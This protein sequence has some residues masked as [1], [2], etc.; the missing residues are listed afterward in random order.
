[1][2][3]II[4]RLNVTQEWEKES[5]LFAKHIREDYENLW[6]TYSF[7]KKFMYLRELERNS[8]VRKSYE[9]KLKDVCKYVGV[10]PNEAVREGVLE[11]HE[12]FKPDSIPWFFEE[13]RVWEGDFSA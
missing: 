13:T 12:A 6:Q 7:C 10:T 11:F 4:S 1:M 8:F 9:D 3:Q 5:L 2:Q